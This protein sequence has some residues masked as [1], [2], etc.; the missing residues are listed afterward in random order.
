MGAVS[1][2]EAPR[3]PVGVHG[4]VLQML[5]NG[6]VEQASTLFERALR[7]WPANSQLQLLKGDVLAHSAGPREAAAHYADLLKNPQLAVWASGRL[8]RLFRESTT[9]PTNTL[10]LARRICAAEIDTRIKEQI[11]DVL[12]QRQDADERL[13]LLEMAA[14]AGILRFE[15]KLAVAKLEGDGDLERARR[16]GRTSLPSSVLLADLLAMFARLPDA[17]GILE[18]L[19]YEFPEYPDIYR[20]LTH[21]LQRAC[22]FTRSADVFEKAVRRWP[23]DWMLVVRLNRLPIERCH[24]ERVFEIIS[25]GADDVLERNERFRF[26][27]ARACLLLDQVEKGLD[28]LAAPFEPAVALMASPLLKA[29]S[30]RTPEHWVKGSRLVDDRL[31]DVQITRAASARATVI[32]TINVSFGNLPHAFV[33]TLFADHGVNVIYLRDF[34]KRSYAR[35]VVG[36]GQDEAETIAA[37]KSLASELGAP[38]TILMGGSSG[39]YSACRYGALM[40]ADTAVSFAGP[41]D[42]SPGVVFRNTRAAAWNPDFF[43]KALLDR[44]KDLQLDLV[45]LLSNPTRTQFLQIFGEENVDDVQQAR[46]LEGLPGVKLRSIPDLGSHYVLDHMIGNGAFDDLLESLLTD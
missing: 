39:G 12:L 34:R 45:P 30:A 35:G 14:D 40:A 5:Q 1:K 29:L 41:T 4:E 22:D 42:A 44:E 36:L 24:L 28:L 7:R 8:L 32:L 27:Y 26:H 31:S 16:E 43:N 37:L 20:R 25:D 33:D 46:R 3:T 9:C 23:H 18:E 15:L 6:E 21:A 13:R 10:D 38:R 17:I 11:L 19:L 2:E